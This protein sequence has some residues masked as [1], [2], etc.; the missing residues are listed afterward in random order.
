MRE[1]RTYG[2]VG[3]AAQYNALSLP[4]PQAYLMMTVA[5]GRIILGSLVASQLAMRIQPALRP[6]PI[7][8]GWLVP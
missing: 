8:S 1:I 3:G 2:S 4:Y 5:P 7:L 6:R